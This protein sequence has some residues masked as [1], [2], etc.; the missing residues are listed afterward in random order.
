M[1][2]VDRLDELLGTTVP[3][4]VRALPD[5]ELEALVELIETAHRQ[6]HEALSHSFDVTL[7]H[8]PF[9]LRNVIRAM[10]VS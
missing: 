10:L 6:Q 7:K 1:A 2:A 3:A 5:A 8:V 4:S 9:P